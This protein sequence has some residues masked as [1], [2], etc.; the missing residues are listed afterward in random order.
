MDKAQ[1]SRALLELERRGHVHRRADAG[2][3]LRQVLV[4]SKSGME[5]YRRVMPDARRSQAAM[6]QV[7]TLQERKA[8]DSALRK[9]KE[10]A[11]AEAADA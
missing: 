9:L 10:F 11:E 7:L 3:E 6:L 4:I 5:L 8:L 1:V 2:H